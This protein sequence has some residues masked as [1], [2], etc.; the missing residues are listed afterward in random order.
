MTCFKFI[1][2]AALS[3]TGEILC[4][5]SPQ[6]SSESQFAMTGRY[7]KQ[8]EIEKAHLNSFHRNHVFR[9]GIVLSQMVLA[10][11]EQAREAKWI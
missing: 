11:H 9:G 5:T 1:C 3:Q 8:R 4:I 2:T 10:S 7:Y 6:P